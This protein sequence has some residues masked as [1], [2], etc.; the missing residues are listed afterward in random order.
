M[1]TAEAGATP[2]GGR[3]PNFLIVG[4]QKCATRWLR[5]HLGRHPDIFTAPRELEFFNNH[6]DDGVESYS[7]LF[8]GAAGKS[9]LGE[10]TPGY[11]MWGRGYAETAARID[12]TLPGVRLLAILRNPVDRAYSAFFHHMARGRIDPDADLLETIRGRSP[13]SDR[14]SLVSGGWYAASLEPYIR[15]FGDRLAV[16]VQDLPDQS[17]ADVY[18]AAVAHLGADRSFAPQDLG[19]VLFSTGETLLKGTARLDKGGRRMPLSADERRVLAEYF[20]EDIERLQ[21]LIGL[22]LSH[23]SSQEPGPSTGAA[24]T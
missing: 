17:L 12:Q 7:A 13:E 2:T 9:L 4:A 18:G 24:R 8:A 3:L 20:E 22:D 6:F 23:W 14:L 1:T 19:T 15:R 5:V 10:A 11:M 21:S 16:L